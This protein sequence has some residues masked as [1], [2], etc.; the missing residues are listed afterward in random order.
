MFA[1]P[2]F[3][4]I[5]VVSGLVMCTWAGGTSIASLPYNFTIAA[6]NTTLPNTNSTGVP[7]VLG[8]NGEYKL[9][10]QM[11]TG[12]NSTLSGSGASTGVSFYVTSVL[13]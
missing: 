12:L 2:L 5:L 1:W 7:L 11:S 10:R 8:Q 9:S 13:H 6:V 3:A 4:K